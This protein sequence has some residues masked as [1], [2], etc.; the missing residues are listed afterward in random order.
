MRAGDDKK[1]RPYF[2]CLSVLIWALTTFPCVHLLDL[3]TYHHMKGI[4]LHPELVAPYYRTITLAT[5]GFSL[6]GVSLLWFLTRTFRSENRD[7]V[8]WG[9][10]S[11]M[12]FAPILWA[13]INPSFRRAA[14]Y[15]LD[16]RNFLYAGFLA[17]A[18]VGE[19][20][21]R[22]LPSQS[23]VPCSADE[24]RQDFYIIALMAWAVILKVL[25]CFDL[26]SIP[27]GRPVLEVGA[28]LVRLLSVAMWVTPVCQYLWKH[29]SRHA[30][31]VIL[32][33]CAAGVLLP[34][35]TGCLLYF[36]VIV[37]VYMGLPP[38]ASA[39]LWGITSLNMVG[40]W[41]PVLLLV[42]GLAWGLIV[43]SLR[44]RYLQVEKN[45]P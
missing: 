29:P 20:R 16:F 10:L 35:L 40:I 30:I 7:A 17:G 21:F 31:Y 45:S 36:P 13:V 18:V 43:G 32:F 1:T 27:P 9:I 6:L 8:L 33:A 2:F 41:K 44:W 3:Y 26:V 25:G 39:A 38:I 19:I 4:G 28:H 34:L 14:A 15:P 23:S 42:P 37:L 5:L 11:G 24:L 12:V 22:S